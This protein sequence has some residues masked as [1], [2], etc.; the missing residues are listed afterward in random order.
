MEPHRKPQAYEKFKTHHFQKRP[1]AG[2]AT[3]CGPFWFRPSFFWGTY[4]ENRRAQGES[5]RDNPRCDVFRSFDLFFR[6]SPARP[7]CPGSPAKNTR[8]SHGSSTTD[9]FTCGIQSLLALPG[10]EPHPTGVSNRA[11]TTSLWLRVVSA[12]GNRP[13]VIETLRTWVCLRT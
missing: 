12:A 3:I 2:S 7:G 9:A 5:L 13:L 8:V 10:T 6:L 4:S 11:D 1:V